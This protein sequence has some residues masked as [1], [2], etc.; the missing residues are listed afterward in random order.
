MADLTLLE[1]KVRFVRRETLRLHKIA[2]GTRLASSLS[3]IEI[4]V[5][6]Y[7]GGVLS[8]NPSAP[9]D[10]GRDRFI[11]SK[12]HGSVSLFPILAELGFFPKA[13]LDRICQEGS[14]LGSIPDPTVPGYETINGSL[15][16]GLGV[17]CGIALGLQLKRSS[18]SVFVL[19][20][21]GEFY[22]G[23]VWEALMFAAEHRL[24][25]LTLIMDN[26]QACMLDYCRN[27]INIDP[28]E[29]KLRCFGWSVTSVD[30]HDIGE[31][32]AALQGAANDRS[33]RPKA[34]IA[35]TVKGKGVPRLEVDSLSH[36]KSLS[37]EEV[38]ALLEEP[39]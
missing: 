19:S 13:E 26:N 34:V 11:V 18:R 30:G 33:G 31:V 6:L 25:N 1:D 36:I 2:P 16:H 28:L 23:A 4:L 29:E 15:G 12:A 5:S 3:P 17:A 8:Y 7:Y 22:E 37:G 21:D 35:N 20:G 10:E 24:D 9:L 38:D 39:E 14:I 27:I 32:Q